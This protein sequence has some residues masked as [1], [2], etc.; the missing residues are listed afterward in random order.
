MSLNVSSAGEW[1]KKKANDNVDNQKKN[2]IKLM[3]ITIA[4]WNGVS[5]SSALIYF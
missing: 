2:Q 1:M 4:T 3:I 5:N